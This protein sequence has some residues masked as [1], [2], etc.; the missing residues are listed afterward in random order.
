MIPFVNVPSGEVARF[1]LPNGNEV[2]AR[3]DGEKLWVTAHGDG[4]PCIVVRPAYANQI[5]VTTQD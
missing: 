1:V 4:A 3:L 2:R 5:S